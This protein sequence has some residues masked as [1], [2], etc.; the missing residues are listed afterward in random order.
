MQIYQAVYNV[1]YIMKEN[2]WLLPF[3]KIVFKVCSTFS[4][5][6]KLSPFFIPNFYYFIPNFPI[7]FIL[8]FHAFS[9]NLG[10]QYKISK[11]LLIICVHSSSNFLLFKLLSLFKITLIYIILIVFSFFFLAPLIMLRLND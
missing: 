4:F 1:T 8:Y 10:I 9:I 2:P 6:S 5:F 11:F 7:C 3:F